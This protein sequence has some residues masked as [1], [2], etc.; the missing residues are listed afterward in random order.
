MEKFISICTMMRL[1]CLRKGEK[2]NGTESEQTGVN[3]RQLRENQLPFLL[4]PDRTGRMKRIMG[5]D[6][7]GFLT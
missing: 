5:D 3:D 7:H 4:S 1:Y 6:Q 2:D